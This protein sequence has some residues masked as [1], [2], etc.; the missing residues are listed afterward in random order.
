MRYTAKRAAEDVINIVGKETGISVLDGLVIL[1]P[2]EVK[3][4]IDWVKWVEGLKQAAFFNQHG[5]C[6]CGEKLIYE[7]ELHH[8]LFSRADLLGTRDDAKNRILN[9]S[10]N[11]IICHK[12]CHEK[13]VRRK[14]LI[15]LIGLFGDPVNDWCNS[16]Y[17]QH[18]IRRF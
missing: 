17:G 9:H 3:D 1:D 5:K 7:G 2:M 16:I 13:A 18:L 12:K 6:M 14:C 15:Y 11:C 10:Y 4:A 8:A